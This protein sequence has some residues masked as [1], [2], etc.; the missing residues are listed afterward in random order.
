MGGRGEIT[1]D[2]QMS[3]HNVSLPLEAE[4]MGS[5]DATALIELATSS[6]GDARNGDAS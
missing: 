2:T 5:L 3:R 1:D 6:P 4:P